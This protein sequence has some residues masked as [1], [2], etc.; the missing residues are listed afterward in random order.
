VTEA[1]DVQP[2]EILIVPVIDVGWTPCFATI[3]G[4][5]SDVGSAISHGAIVAREYGLP[6]IVNLRNATATFRTG[7]FVEL[8]ADRGTLQRLAEE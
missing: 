6:A 4:L 3:A 1:G 2:N 5:A 8:D 7:D